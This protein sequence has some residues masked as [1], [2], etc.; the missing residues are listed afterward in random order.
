MNSIA[1][2]VMRFLRYIEARS[3]VSTVEYAL[4]VVAVIAIVGAAMTLLSGN[5]TTL[6]ETIGADMDAQAEAMG[7]LDGGDD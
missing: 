7:E 5:F 6:F 4:I 3:G 2:A 1:K